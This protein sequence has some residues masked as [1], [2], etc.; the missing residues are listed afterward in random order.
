[1]STDDHKPGRKS[2]A[3][4]TVV[5]PTAFAPRPD[6][7]PG[8]SEAEADLWRHIVASLPADWFDAGSLPILTAYVRSVAVCE[9]LAEM[10]ARLD[11]L[12]DPEQF[13]RYAAL[14]RLRDRESH[15]M[16]YMA[17]KLRLT[18]QSRYGA[19][20]ADGAARRAPTGPKPW[21]FRG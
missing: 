6:P 5:C 20:G 15:G 4:L 8:L 12:A 14:L 21:D 9:L 19:R 1:M 16:A 13:K 2:A 11:D 18:Q 17:T 3:S 7:G 10:I